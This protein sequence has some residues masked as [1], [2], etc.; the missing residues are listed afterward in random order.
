[1]TSQTKLP[2][3]VALALLLG[4]SAA[5][6][7]P[8]VPPSTTDLQ[9]VRALTSGTFISLTNFQNQRITCGVVSVP[10]NSPQNP[11]PQNHDNPF[12]LKVAETDDETPRFKI[13]H[14]PKSERWNYGN[15]AQ[16]RFIRD[17]D[18]VHLMAAKYNENAVNTT[19]MGAWRYYLTV[20][21]ADFSFHDPLKYNADCN[22]FGWMTDTDAWQTFQ[23]QK[24]SKSQFD[25]DGLIRDAD[26]L[27][28]KPC[29]SPRLLTSGNWSDV[30]RRDQW[31]MDALTL[32]DGEFS[33]GLTGPPRRNQ[34][35]TVKI[36]N[37]PFYSASGCGDRA[38]TYDDVD[39][40]VGE[41]V[42]PA[43]LSVEYDTDNADTRRTCQRVSACNININNATPL[44]EAQ[45]IVQTYE[46]WYEKGRTVSYTSG[47]ENSTTDD[48][49]SGTENS[50][51]LEAAVTAK[52]FSCLPEVTWTASGTHSWSESDSLSHTATFSTEHGLEWSEVERVTLT[53]E[54]NCPPQQ[55]F[56]VIVMQQ[57]A[58]IRCPM[59]AEYSNGQKF[60]IGDL[61]MS[62]GEEVNV[63]ASYLPLKSD[64]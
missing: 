45:N 16:D 60:Y 43:L 29:I 38:I 46:Q 62:S 5:T 33:V 47:T 58:V 3:L 30:D 25:N 17:G 18:F 49:T 21:P 35:L 9:P 6:G 56:E 24:V 14:S 59:L 64:L 28:L 53:T 19:G 42:N 4:A 23:V 27:V 36:G 2:L 63:N 20:F 15:E 40:N 51:T 8:H 61:I 41:L 11:T 31:F 39:G 34:I 22:Q 50:A 57:S 13:I 55:C 1:M 32:E 48:H 12:G 37:G 54:C 7:A 26:Q 52:I 44:A 10:A